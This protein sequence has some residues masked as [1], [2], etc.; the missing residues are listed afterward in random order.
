MDLVL[1]SAALA[2]TAHFEGWETQPIWDNLIAFFDLT[3]LALSI[4]YLL[5]PDQ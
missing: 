3:Y 2:T 4:A 1:L 5:P